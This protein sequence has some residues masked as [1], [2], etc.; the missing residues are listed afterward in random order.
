MLLETNKI[1]CGDCLELMKQI[2]DK[3][4]DLVLT[5]PPYGK[6]CSKG[7]GGYGDSKTRKYKDVWD[8]NTPSDEV[9]EEI[10]RISEKQI[11]FGGNY[12]KLPLSNCWFV[13]DKKGDVEFN[14]PFGDC[15]LIWTNFKKV[16]KKYTFKQQ[17]FVRESKDIV[18]HPTQKPTELIK[19]IILDWTEDNSLILDP[20]LGSGTTAVACK[21]LGRRYIGI[22][23]NPEY[24]KIAEERL[25]QE[26]LF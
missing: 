6:G 10:F 23:I 9:F 2:P 25:R 13:W 14:N 1:Y 3:S 21:E 26:Y 24:C 4:I 22:E 12:F 16:V 8:K 18:V 5:D 15:E 11:I 19:K 7:T 17:G 20:F